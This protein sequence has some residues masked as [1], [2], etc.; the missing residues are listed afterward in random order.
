MIYVTHDQTEALTFADQVVVMNDG[1]VVQ[2]GTPVELFEQP[3]HTFVGHFIGSPGMNVLPCEVK[4]GK[5]CFAG[6]TIAVGNAA[7]LQ[8][9]RARLE[10]GVRPEF[11]SLRR[12]GIPVRGRARWPMPA[13]TGSS[14]RAA[15]ATVDQAAGRRRATPC[16]RAGASRLRSRAHAGLRR[17]LDGGSAPMNKTVNKK[18]WLL[19]LPGLPAGGVQ[20][21]HPADDGRQLFGAGNL[22]RQRVLLVGRAAGSSRCCMSTASTP[23]CS[24]Q[25]I[26]TAIV[27]VIEVPLGVA[28]ALTMPRK[29]PWVSVC[30]VLMAL[31]L[32]IPW[33]VVGAM[34][35]IFALPDIGLLGKA[36]N[37]LGIRLQLHAPAASPPGSR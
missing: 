28:I 16:R 25:L 30:L 2:T 19:V 4:G 6:Q 31:P 23:R 12:A 36:L 8:P 13:A 3:R 15:T 14:R 27:L 22:R 11:V 9:A 21:A 18:A 32:L 5:A 7:Q 24:R 10:L 34:W 17:R 1:E 26:F 29:G 33:N 37:A 35:N 20:R